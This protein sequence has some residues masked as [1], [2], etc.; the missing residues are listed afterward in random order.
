MSQDAQRQI[1]AKMQESGHQGQKPN[2]YRNK[3]TDVHGIRFDSKKEAR[4]FGD[5]MLLQ[6]TGK[7]KDLRLQQDFTL[8]E[9]YTTPEGIRIR[10]VRYRADFCY[11]EL[12]GEN[13]SYVVE[14]VK[15]GGTRTREYTI[16]RKL[17]R[18]KYGIDIR[19]V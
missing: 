13:W 1:L 18:S 7:I 5:L 9:A 8:E 14:D 4:R 3:K 16:K 19:E 15:S 11:L 2:K 10:A 17:M 6:K 12:N